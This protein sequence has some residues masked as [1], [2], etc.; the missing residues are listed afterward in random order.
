MSLTTLTQYLPRD[1]VASPAQIIT[2][3]QEGMYHNETTK[4]RYDSLT[5]LLHLGFNFDHNAAVTATYL[6]HLL[7]GNIVTDLLS[8]GGKTPKTGPP[9]PAPAHAGGLSVHGTFEGTYDNAQ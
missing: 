2:A 4:V 1:G 3:V 6:G 8:I 5:L 7:N 9:P